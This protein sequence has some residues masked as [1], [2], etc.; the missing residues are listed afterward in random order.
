ME[1]NDAVAE[2]AFAEQLELDADAVGE[3]L[4]AT[5]HDDGREEQVE[6]VH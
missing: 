4:L 1:L 2:T 3:R 5:A 6:L